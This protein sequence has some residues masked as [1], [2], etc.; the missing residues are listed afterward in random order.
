TTLLNDKEQSIYL[1]GGLMRNPLNQDDYKSFF[2]SFNLNSLK[3][4]V[5]N[6]KGTLPERQIS[7][8]GVADNT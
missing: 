2:H 3:W 6:V 7:M 4:N 5:P 1:L 8:K